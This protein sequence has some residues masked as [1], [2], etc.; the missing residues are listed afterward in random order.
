LLLPGEQRTLN[1]DELMPYGYTGV[2]RAPTAAPTTAAPTPAPV[3]TPCSAVGCGAVWNTIAS[4][5]QGTCSTQITWVKNNGYQGA[6]SW[7]DACRIVGTQPGTPECAPCAP[8]LSASP[9]PS[10]LAPAIPALGAS[11]QSTFPATQFPGHDFG[12]G[13]AIDGIVGSSSNWNFALSELNAAN[14][15]LSI[16]IMPGSTVTAVEVYPRQ[17][18]FLDRLANFQ[19]WVGNTAGDISRAPGMALCGSMTATATQGPFTVRCARAL[20]GS[21]VTVRLPGLGRVLTLSEVTVHG[22]AA[23]ATAAPTPSPS[24]VAPVCMQNVRLT[25]V[26][27]RNEGQWGTSDPQVWVVNTL[28][29]SRSVLSRTEVVMNNLNPSFQQALTFAPPAQA[30]PPPAP[31]TVCFEVRDNYPLD[32]PP[33]LHSGCG[34]LSQSSQTEQSVQLS[35]SATVYVTMCP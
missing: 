35:D 24:P 18:T 9:P 29:P 2:T 12:A 28:A 10:A 1:V 16:Q 32:P 4:N 3:P 23:P 8:A 11:M 19:V 13:Q 7:D 17:D 26:F 15:W 30:L 6:S 5:G 22:N 25:N 33:L 21:V 14:P 31:I 27:A 20:P 34:T